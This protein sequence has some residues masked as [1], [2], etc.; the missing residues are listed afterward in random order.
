MTFFSIAPFLM[1][2]RIDAYVLKGIFVS[3]WN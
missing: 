2:T 3:E 1:R